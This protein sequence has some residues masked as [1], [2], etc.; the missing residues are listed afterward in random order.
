MQSRIL[1]E[2]GGTIAGMSMFLLTNKQFR[3]SP[4]PLLTVD[5]S[6]YPC[7]FHSSASSGPTTRFATASFH[8]IR[9]RRYFCFSPAGIRAG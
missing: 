7:F 9:V 4:L 1:C 5:N 6:G 2:P 8:F 3:T